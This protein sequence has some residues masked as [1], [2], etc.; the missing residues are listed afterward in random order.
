[1]AKEPLKQISFT[2]EIGD[3]KYADILDVCER[4]ANGELANATNA[5]AWL[6][7]SSPLY[8]KTLDTIVAER[9]ATAGEPI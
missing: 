4:L 7:R 6:I 3:N 9:K 8:R 1:M 5:A 2:R